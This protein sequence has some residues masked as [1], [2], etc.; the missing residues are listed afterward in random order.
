[1]KIQVNRLMLLDALKVGGAV[2]GKSK[3]IPILDCCKV[4]IKG[5]KMIVTS[6]D[7]EI[8]IAKKVAIIKSDVEHGDFCVVPSDL[9]TILS[10]LRQEDVTLEVDDSS[11][12]L[13]HSRGTAKVAVLPATDFPT[14]ASNENKTTFTMDANKLSEWLDAAKSFVAVDPLR[15]AL[16]GM[17]LAIENGEVWSC[18]SDS[19]KLYMDGYK[20]ETMYGISVSMIIPSKMLNYASAVLGGRSSV[21]VLA[22][23]NNVS[24]VVADAK[25]SARLVVGAYPKVRQLLPKQTPIVVEVNTDDF[26][27]SISRMK[28][29]ADQKSKMVELSFSPDGV[30]MLSSDILYNK[31]CVDSCDVIMYDGDPIDVCTKTDSLDAIL[32]KIDSETIAIGI[33]NP[34]SP[35]VIYEADNK[36][37]VLFTMPLLKAK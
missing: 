15:P 32:S 33:T 7:S 14:M 24:F 31:S 4:S 9:T 23:D 5:G 12:A 3:A 20:D 35:I 18:A 19:F 29:F 1:M 34:K 37:K 21:T 13:C 30:E 6:T 26:K 16:T 27:G 2:A 25:I 22:D 36:N 17:Y 8:T 10:T 28:L 11:C